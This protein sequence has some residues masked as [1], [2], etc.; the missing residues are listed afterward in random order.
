[1]TSMTSK[2]IKFL[3]QYSGLSQTEFGK[4]FNLTR[5]MVDSYERTKK[6]GEPVAEPSQATIKEIA[7]HYNLSLDTIQYKDLQASPGLMFAQNGV[8]DLL[9]VKESDLLKAKDD[10]IKELRQ[11]IKYL[12]AQNETLNSMLNR[13][14]N[15]N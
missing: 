1:M 3:R 15:E 5:G 12:Q 9:N 13:R 14:K 7:D 8:T 11:H 10:L 6:S 4:R 2:N